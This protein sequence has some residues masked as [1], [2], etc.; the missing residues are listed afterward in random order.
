MSQKVRIPS[1][2]R[3]KGSGQAV[4]VLG[5]KSFYLGKWDTPHS[6]AEYGRV[7]A[8][9]LA[10]NTCLANAKTASTEANPTACPAAVRINELMRIN[11][12]I[13]AFW[14]HAEKHYRHPDG[15]SS[16]ELSNL[17]DALRPLRK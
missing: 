16:G 5:G 14:E 10:N 6:R 9:W 7:I 8:E 1:Y 3:H 2:R 13:L 11:E 15:R 12:L 4:V 17:R